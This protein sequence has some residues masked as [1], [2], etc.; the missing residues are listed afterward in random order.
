MERCAVVSKFHGCE[1]RHRLSVDAILE[2]RKFNARVW[3]L[4]PAAVMRSQ[5]DCPRIRS[6]R[7]ALIAERQI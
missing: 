4:V 1:S 6:F 3:L 5:S 2:G 7:V